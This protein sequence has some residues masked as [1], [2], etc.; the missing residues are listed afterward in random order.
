MSQYLLPCPNCQNKL[1]VAKSQAGMTVS[2]PS[3]EANVQVPT[4]RGFSTLSPAETEVSSRRGKNKGSSPVL[5]VLSVIFLLVSI[6]CLSYAGYLYSFRAS[7][8]APLDLSEEDLVLD[9]RQAMLDMPPATAWDT[10]NEISQDGVT[11]TPIPPYFVFKR[12]LEAQR[13]T[14]LTCFYVGSG[15]FVA[16]LATLFLSRRAK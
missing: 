2:C 5:G 13:P 11:E 16:F 1:T 15:C 9:I 12:M 8:S 10:W 7:F 14:M 4:V 3:C 6:P